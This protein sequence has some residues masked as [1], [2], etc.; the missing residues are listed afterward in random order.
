MRFAN[1]D[2]RSERV[3]LN[4]NEFD[5]CQFHQC[6]MVFNGVGGVGLSHCGFHDCRWTFEGPAGDTVRFMKALYA[7]GGG[8][9]DLILATFRD[10]APDLK[11]R[12]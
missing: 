10:V 8:G 3:N 12:H 2:F 6:E 4:G 9:R 5:H 7:I 11:F 1:R